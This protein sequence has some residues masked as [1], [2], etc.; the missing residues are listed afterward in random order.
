MDW[1]DGCSVGIVA[2]SEGYPGAPV[3]DRKIKGIEEAEAMEGVQVFQ[4]G[5]RKAPRRTVFSAGGRVLAVVAQGSDREE[6]R[7]RAYAGME[8]IQFEGMHYRL[9]IAGESRIVAATK[10]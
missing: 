4:A 9:D 3:V 8:Q 2:C 7:T 6:A 5:T 10:T 1:H